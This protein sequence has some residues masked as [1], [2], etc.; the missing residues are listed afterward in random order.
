MCFLAPVV[1]NDIRHIIMQN[2]LC[3][4]MLELP[5][6]L[7]PVFYLHCPQRCESLL[8]ENENIF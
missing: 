4:L 1:T 6:K 3:P 8:T 2:C 5:P 7:S